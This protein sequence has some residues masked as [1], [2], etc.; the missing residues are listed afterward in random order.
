MS[1]R[2]FI[3]SA[4]G[5]AALVASSVVPMPR[6]LLWNASGSVTVG[7]YAVL[8]ARPRIGDLVAVEPPPRWRAWMVARRYIGEHAPLLKQIAAGPGAVVCRLDTRI[9]IDGK[10]A[11]LARSHDRK[12]RAL[13]VWQGCHHLAQG[14]VFLLNPDA[15]LSLDGRYFGLWPSTVIIGRA[16]PLWLRSAS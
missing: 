16:V 6:L 10:F 5:V 4:I 14:Q 12:G 9:T 8:Q 7:L 3:V 15:P 1:M 13:P 11:A 2:L